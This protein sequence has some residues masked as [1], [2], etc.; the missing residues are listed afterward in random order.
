LDLTTAKAGGDLAIGYTTDFVKRSAPALSAANL[1]HIDE[2]L[3][4]ACDTT[5]ANLPTAAGKT[6]ADAIGAATGR[7]PGAK[8]KTLVGDAAT[9]IRAWLFSV[10]LAVRRS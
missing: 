8:I 1:N 9:Q 6:A 2:A 10:P 3:K 4:D 5:D 7:I